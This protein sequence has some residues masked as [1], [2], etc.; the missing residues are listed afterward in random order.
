ML[1]CRIPGCGRRR[2]R[3]GSQGLAYFLKE[4]DI[5]HAIFFMK[6]D[7]STQLYGIFGHPVA[8]SL[9][10]AIHNAAFDALGINAAYLAFDV[11][12]LAGAVG[13][14]RAL[15]IRG[16]SVTI[17]HK[18]AIM[19]YLDEVELLASRIGAV[20]TVVNDTGRLK[21]VNT[22]WRG[23]ISALEE[24]VSLTG[25]RA[26]VLGAGGAA[27][28]V[29]AGLVHERALVHI[30]NRTAERAR[31]VADQ[32]RCTWSSLG[33][34]DELYGD[35][36]IN[37]TS[38]GMEPDAGKMPVTA[39]VLRRFSVVMDIV[40]APVETRLLREAA[41]AGLVTI[42]GLRM[43]LWQA[44]AQFETWTGLKAPIDVMERV[45]QSRFA[46]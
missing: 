32:V 23:A 1:R 39:G 25:K 4:Q 17:P 28:A 7:A 13:G 14:V 21:G 5:L 45:L 46:A 34:T 22:D 27:R 26:V 3:F 20:N 38:V 19:E 16:L 12:D 11:T 31:E 36:L 44:V 42:N 9:S 30:A 35:I 10:P 43:L 15:G 29:V 18:T 37:T 8:H 40:Y 33:E 2:S 6:P 24:K 41:A